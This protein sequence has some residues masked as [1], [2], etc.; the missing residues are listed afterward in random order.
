MNPRLRAS[1]SCSLVLFATLGVG[2]GAAP[3]E[4]AATEGH[5][6]PRPPTSTA[7]A[8]SASAPTPIA[9]AVAPPMKRES[10]FSIALVADTGSFAIHQ[11]PGLTTIEIDPMSSAPT[12]YVVEGDHLREA[13]E[14]SRG[15]SSSVT[16]FNT[17]VDVTWFFTTSLEGTWP[18][19][20]VLHASAM[21][22][23]VSSRDF[24]WKGDRWASIPP[25]KGP[26]LSPEYQLALERDGELWETAWQG[27][28]LW[29]QDWAKPPVLRVERAARAKPPR[30]RDVQEPIALAAS[31]DG[32]VFLVGAKR[33][34]FEGESRPDDA[35]VV[36]VVAPGA[37]EGTTVPLPASAR[38]W[39][40]FSKDPSMVEPTTY[41][42]G[43][44]AIVAVSAR[45]AYV[46][47]NLPSSTGDRKA[48]SEGYLA[49]WDGATFTP[50]GGPGDELNSFSVEESGAPSPRA[51]MGLLLR[52]GSSVYWKTQTGLFRAAI[53]GSGAIERLTPIGKKVDFVSFDPEGRI[54]AA[55]DGAIC[56][57]EDDGSFTE[58]ALPEI[59]RA[60]NAEGPP[61]PVQLAWRTRDDLLAFVTTYGPGGANGK[62][63]VLRTSPSRGAPI[64]AA[65][66]T[67]PK[68]SLITPATPSCAQTFV[69]L[70]RLSRVA[71]PDYDFPATRDALKGR[72]DLAGIRFA[73]TLDLG[74]RYLVGFAPTFAA[75]QRLV[76]A[77]SAKIPSAR[78]QILCGKPAQEVRQVRWDL[79]TGTPKK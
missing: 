32:A 58:L 7:P 62:L 79:A 73:E 42:F 63:T 48:R 29:V 35:L 43:E 13:P 20:A 50:M 78:A 46:A 61:Q 41:A 51:S 4:G 19:A 3:P 64:A 9:A 16:F 26:K 54:F 53:G 6:A 59:A 68:S 15:R 55:L 25:A 21:S 40:G 47:V 49:R 11:I 66:S 77:I 70:Y 72:T 69:V 18:G 24:Q 10:P 22:R 37:S 75:G 23:D 12:R 39:R 76:E 57:R 52:R 5:P 17:K 71:P 67:A 36:E 65:G 27:G 30:W 74:R 8:A 1:L 38:T 31:D 2:C 28:T 45:E 34:V 56:R 60:P 44:A 33:H 14:L